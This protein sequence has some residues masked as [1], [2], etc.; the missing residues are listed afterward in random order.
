MERYF[1]QVLY[2]MF[3]IP[4]ACWDGEASFVQ[5]SSAQPDAPVLGDEKLRGELENI[6]CRNAF[7][8][9]YLEDEWIYY[10]IFRDI[11][12]GFACFGPVSVQKMKKMD[13]EEY[14]KR[15]NLKS[16]PEIRYMGIGLM[17]KLLALAF[18]QS[19]G[20]KPDYADIAVRCRK[21]GLE[22]WN[23]EQTLGDYMLEQSETDRGHER[24]V[25]F[26]NLLMDTVRNGD[27][28]KVKGL[29]S[30]E[31]PQIEDIAE[32]SP[33]HQ[34]EMEYIHII[35]IT[36]LTR[37]AVEGG[38]PRR[39]PMSW[40]MSIC[41]SWKTA[42]GIQERSQCLAIGRRSP[43]QRKSGRQKDREASTFMWISVRTI[44]RK[45]CGKISVSAISLRLS[46]SAAGICLTDSPRRREY[47]FSST[48][49]R[50]SVIM[51][52]IC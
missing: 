34:R 12:G 50:K 44:S 46:A 1:L 7:P 2:D 51:R 17:T 39:Q 37:A 47:R 31:T 18:S 49:F 28:E 26:E 4:M 22:D 13:L 11:G 29:I 3:Q 14:R 48:F 25:R 35:T 16:L 42:A 38:V 41:V 27:V 15:H 9:I 40:G 10:G 8:V 52:P 6:C 21:I 24:G 33:N 45:I 23:Q 43:L 36:L 32:F 30:G 5:P 20:E 19:T